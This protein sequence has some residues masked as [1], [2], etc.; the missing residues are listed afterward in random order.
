MIV[1]FK[2]VQPLSEIGEKISHN[3]ILRGA[4]N[5]PSAPLPKGTTGDRGMLHNQ[6]ENVL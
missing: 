6:K 2:R 1:A 4:N 5:V 3:D